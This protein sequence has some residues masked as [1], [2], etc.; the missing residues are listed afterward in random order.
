MDTPVNVALRREVDNGPRPMLCKEAADFRPVTNVTMNEGQT[1]VALDRLKV[2][3][4]PRVGETVKDD[5]GL[6]V[7]FK[8][9]QDEVAPNEARTTGYQNHRS[10]LS[11][12]DADAQL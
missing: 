9:V 1:R 10:A 7:P 5:D 2:L 4:V 3:K 11:A 6:A 12:K 8:P